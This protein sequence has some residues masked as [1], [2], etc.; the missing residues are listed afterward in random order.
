[1]Q[2]RQFIVGSFVGTYSVQYLDDCW[3]HMFRSVAPIL[4]NSSRHH[5][6]YMNLPHKP[7]P[8]IVLVNPFWI[9]IPCQGRVF[10]RQNEKDSWLAFIIRRPILYTILQIC[11]NPHPGWPKYAIPLTINSTHLALLI[12]FCT[13]ILAFIF[14]HPTEREQ[15]FQWVAFAFCAGKSNTNSVWG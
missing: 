11:S 15:S 6:A 9:D 4:L 10:L 14:L 7:I 2:P 13:S 8:V 1:M 12:T 5:K 3:E